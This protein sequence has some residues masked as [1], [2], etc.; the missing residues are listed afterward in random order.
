MNISKYKIVSLTRNHIMI[1]YYYEKDGCLDT[2]QVDIA[3]EYL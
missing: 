2:C 1:N 3:L